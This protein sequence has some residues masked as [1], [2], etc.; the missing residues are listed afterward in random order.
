LNVVEQQLLSAL[1][2][3]PLETDCSVSMQVLEALGHITPTQ[4][5]Q[6]LS[7]HRTP[8]DGK[9]WFAAGDRW[10]YCTPAPEPERAPIAVPRP[11]A[12]RAAVLGS[13]L[14]KPL[15]PLKRAAVGQRSSR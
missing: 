6:W 13:I 15:T 9:R 5:E 1:R 11:A 3:T 12:P 4:Q 14:V 10:E 8:R 2:E 7:K